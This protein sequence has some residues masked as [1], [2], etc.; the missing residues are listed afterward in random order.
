M[1]VGFI[2][3][4][5]MGEGV[6]RRILGGGHDLAAYDPVPGKAAQ[7]AS[8]GAI[9][10]DSIARACEG[11]DVVITMLPDDRSLHDAVLGKA[12]VRDSLAPKAIHIA[13]GTHGVGT[14]QAVA[15]A[16]A[17]SNQNFIAAPVLGRPDIAAAGQL[18]IIA[19]GPKEAVSQ[20]KPLFDLISRRVFDAGEK[21]DGAAAMKLANSFLLGC[22]IQAMAEAFSLVRKY[23]V[24]PHALY[25][26]LT[27][28]L[29]AAP[30][31]KIYGKIIADESYDAVGFTALL[32]LKDA[33]LA[34]AASDA[35]R[36]P[37]PSV[38]A[39]RDRLLSV[40][41]QGDG[42]KDWAV[43]AKEQARASG[44]V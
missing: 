6:A 12:G 22:A 44:L 19:A 11:R 20:C 25:D 35:A 15:A 43:L 31:Y 4:G 3:L 39:L 13:L 7:L 32:G 36:V 34:L 2:G 9:A 41:A 16:H 28:G 14:T 29:F 38:N 18:G 10:A 24:S 5:R 30:A 33:N 42:D 40:I 23:D 8:A 1:K 37:L 27:D 21:Q 17:E 26:V